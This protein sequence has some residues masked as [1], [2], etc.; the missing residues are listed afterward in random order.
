MPKTTGGP[1]LRRQK[2]RTDR[3]APH[4]WGRG[5]LRTPRHDTLGTPRGPS[6]PVSRSCLLRRRARL[7]AYPCRFRGRQRSVLVSVT[8]QVS[9]PRMGRFDVRQ[10]AGSVAADGQIKLA[11]DT[12]VLNSDDGGDRGPNHGQLHGGR[13]EA[14]STDFARSL[15]PAS[16]ARCTGSSDG[17]ASYRRD[18][19]VGTDREGG[20]GDHV[21]AVE[22]VRRLDPNLG[23]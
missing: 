6:T 21:R 7:T 18:P 11:I 3:Q 1:L 17:F 10:W 15:R 23:C 12:A 4:V 19:L 9:W 22:C 2:R 16:M 20:A 13:T 5:R 8:V 14:F